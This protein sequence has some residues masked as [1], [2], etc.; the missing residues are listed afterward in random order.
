MGSVNLYNHSSTDDV[1]YI[2]CK[3]LILTEDKDITINDK[4]YIDGRE[5]KVQFVNNA[6]RLAQVYVC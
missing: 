2:D 4:A 5:Y 1:R 6:G 3:Y